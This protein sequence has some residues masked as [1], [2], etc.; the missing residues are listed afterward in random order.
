[1]KKV[2]EKLG[3]CFKYLYCIFLNIPQIINKP[4]I[5]EILKKCLNKKETYLQ[6]LHCFIYHSH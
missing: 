2:E 1:M 6:Y 5:F 4:L 3:V